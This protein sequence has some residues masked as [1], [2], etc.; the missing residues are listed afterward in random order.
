[1]FMKLGPTN[2]NLIPGHGHQGIGLRTWHEI[3][4]IQPHSGLGNHV[5]GAFGRHAPSRLLFQR[6][7]EYPMWGT[8]KAVLPFSRNFNS[9]VYAFLA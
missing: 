4:Q 9:F 7:N 2:P 3:F 1:M 5:K 8:C 6:P